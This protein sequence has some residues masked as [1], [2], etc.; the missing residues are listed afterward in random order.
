MRFDIITLFPEMINALHYG[1]PQRAQQQGLLEIKCWNPRDFAQNKHRNVD[2]RPYGG[3]PGMVMMAQPLQDA[4]LAAKKDC[5]I[6]AN[7]IYLSPQGRTVTQSF[8]KQ[9]SDQRFIFLC[10]RYEGIDE[11]LIDLV[12]DEEWSIGDYVLSGGEFAAMAMV[13]ALIRLQPGA[14][15]HEDSAEQ[16]SFSQ[17]L[18]D[19]PHYT[20]PEI[21]EGVAVPKVLLSGDHQAI[22]AWR[23]QQAQQRTAQRRPDL[24]ECKKNGE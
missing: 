2:D 4:V 9:R 17:G 19:Y 13:D 1:I 15:G 6:A 5:T 24:L 18:L 12:V 23:M 8:L 20:R 16:D 21:F 22:Q 7:V 11:R 3:G 10:G 14:L